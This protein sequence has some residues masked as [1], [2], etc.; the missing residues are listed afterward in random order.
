MKKKGGRERKQKENKALAESSI[1]S[2][3]NIFDLWFMAVEQDELE[4]D[5]SSCLVVVVAVF[6]CLVHSRRCL[7]AAAE[8][9]SYEFRCTD[10]LTGFREIWIYKQ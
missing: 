2:D 3:F 10:Y 1:K 7:L 5:S 6:V 4:E 9:E 8:A